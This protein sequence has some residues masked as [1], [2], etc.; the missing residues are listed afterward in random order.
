MKTNQAATTKPSEP[1][2][3][4]EP[5]LPGVGTVLDLDALDECVGG[6]GDAEGVG[7]YV[8]STQSKVH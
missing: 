7:C 5:Q 4:Q 1:A 3:V 8:H 6:R 2:R